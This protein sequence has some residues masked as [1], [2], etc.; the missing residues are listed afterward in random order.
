MAANS[1]TSNID[2]ELEGLHRVL[3]TCSMANRDLPSQF[4]T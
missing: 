3:I 4:N 2:S 1:C